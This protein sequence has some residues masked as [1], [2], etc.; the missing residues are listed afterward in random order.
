M[1]EAAARFEDEMK[2]LSIRLERDYRYGPLCVNAGRQELKIVFDNLIANALQC[3]NKDGGTLRL[4]TTLDEGWVVAEV[5]DSGGGIDPCHLAS[6]F[7]PFFT[8][9][10]DGTGLGLPITS[11]IVSRLRGV[12]DVINKVGEGVTFRV[13]LPPSRNNGDMGPEAQR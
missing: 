11:S 3:M 13:K 1:D 9:K 12:I 7:R 2:R 4:G 10:K 8:T 6:I 5:S